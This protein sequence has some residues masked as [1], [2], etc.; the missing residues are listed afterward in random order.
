MEKE[1]KQHNGVKLVINYIDINLTFE[2]YN[3][4]LESLAERQGISRKNARTQLINN[5]I[6]SEVLLDVID[7]C[8]LEYFKKEELKKKLEEAELKFQKKK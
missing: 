8:T 5:M 6:D 1:K 2:Q 7:S 3:C 4:I